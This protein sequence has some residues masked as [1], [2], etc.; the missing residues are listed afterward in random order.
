MEILSPQA[1]VQSGAMGAPSVLRPVHLNGRSKREELNV[2]VA[3]Q[4]E[5]EF[6]KCFICVLGVHAADLQPPGLAAGI[7]GP[8]SAAK[9]LTLLDF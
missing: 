3:L 7:Y 6:H 9:V 2:A 1:S 4:C 5:S 8:P